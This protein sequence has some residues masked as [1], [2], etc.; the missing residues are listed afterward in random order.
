MSTAPHVV[1]VGAGALGGWT[2]LWLVR[3][4]A[5]VTLVDAYGPGNSRSSSGG[6]TRVIRQ[7]YADP[8]H[9]DLAGRALELWRA[10]ESSF[11]RPVLERRGALFLVQEPRRAFAAAARA[12]FAARGVAHEDLAPREVERRHPWISAHDVEDA[13]FEPG[14][15]V[16]H[17]RRACREVAERVALEGG[18]VVLAAARLVDDGEAASHVELSN[19]DRVA[20]DRFVLACGPWLP[21]LVPELAAFLTTSRQE[22]VFFAPPPGLAATLE[23]SAPVWADLGAAFWYGIPGGEHRGFKGADDTR[24]APVDPDGERRVV[25]DDTLARTAGYL[26]RRFPP[27]AGSPVVETRVCQY[28]DTPDDDHLFDRHPRLANAFVLGGGCGHAFKS[29]PAIAEIAA[30][31]VLGDGVGPGRWR[32]D[33]TSSAV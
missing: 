8:F 5:R 17:A 7:A 1:V 27:L 25:G 9:A 30:R 10:E 14:A 18:T 15:G 2:A 20:A 29:G 13:F 23:R 22:V 24:G 11:S 33:R 19:G 31:A 26:A 4:G 3:A 16:L 21:R 12:N 28:T 6:E 32:I